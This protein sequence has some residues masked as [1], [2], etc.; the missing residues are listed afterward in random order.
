MMFTAV[1]HTPVVYF[2]VTEVG[3]ETFKHGAG[4]NSDKKTF[5]P[6]IIET[7]LSK[8]VLQKTGAL[9]LKDGVHL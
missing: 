3:S 1:I 5:F 6:K 8:F 2:H 7:N 9:N 4:F